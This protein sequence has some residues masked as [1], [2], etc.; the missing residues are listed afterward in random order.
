MYVQFKNFNKE[1]LKDIKKDHLRTP[2][3][4]AMFFLNIFIQQ[5]VK[6]LTKNFKKSN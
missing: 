3:K 6:I 2:Q 1:Y 5:H 4:K